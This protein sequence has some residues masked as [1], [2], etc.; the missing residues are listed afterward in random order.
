MT[1]IVADPYLLL[2]PDPCNS[3][4]QIDI[5]VEGLLNWSD[6]ASRKDIPMFISD[7]CISGL[8]ADNWYPYHGR[9]SPL[10]KK[11]GIENA[12][13]ETINQV[14]RNIFDK[15]PRLEDHLEI[16]SVLYEEQ[17]V[18]VSPDI[19]LRRLGE[20]TSK[21]LSHTLVLMGIGEKCIGSVLPECYI[22]TNEDSH[23]QENDKVTT[24]SEVHLIELTE[25]SQYHISEENL[26]QTIENDLTVCFGYDN[27]LSSMDIM[28][29][30]DEA[31][32]PGKVTDTINKMLI[33]HREAGLPPDRKEFCTYRLGTHFL[34]SI[35]SY[36]FHARPD[37]AR[38]LIDSCARI[39]LGIPKNDVDEFREDER[40]QS[41]QRTRKSDQALAWRTHLTKSN[42]GF[43]LMFWTTSDG[44]VEF[45]NVGPKKEL[46]IYE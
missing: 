46:I 32:S 1:C 31:S 8:Y 29:L 35:H 22:A 16:A 23:I 44:I 37:W 13:E 5:F 19:F 3:S 34:E 41:V 4:E 24:S 6:A 18:V 27:V 43:R 28:A 15:T 30:W 39:I 42:E 38:L 14:I 9:L 25:N 21:A 20:N 36:G 26:P 33:H 40:S 12:D 2:L 7:A 45:A 17:S 11:Y 10:F